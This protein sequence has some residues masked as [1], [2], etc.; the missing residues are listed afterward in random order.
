MVHCECQKNR[1]VSNEQ[2][3]FALNGS[4]TS[5]MMNMAE[6]L[7][8]YTIQV[9]WQSSGHQESKLSSSMPSMLQGG[10][11]RN[12]HIHIIGWQFICQWL[13]CRADTTVISGLLQKK[14]SA[15]IHY[16]ILV[17]SGLHGAATGAC[18]AKGRP[19]NYIVCD[20]VTEYK[21]GRSFPSLVAHGTWLCIAEHALLQLACL[22]YS[23][24]LLPIII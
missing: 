8:W 4:D 10:R 21:F 15:H 7:W 18:W 5:A 12:M 23:C 22:L 6:A 17:V 16:D 19:C 3:V 11:M 24:P 2:L 20:N 1:A 13:V 9:R 14:E